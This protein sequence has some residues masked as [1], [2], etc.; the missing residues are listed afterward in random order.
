MASDDA[1]AMVLM[2]IGD[3][4]DRF[5]RHPAPAPALLWSRIAELEE[6]Q[7]KLHDME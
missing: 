4:S 3:S 1:T 5:S 6:L 7:N 2:L